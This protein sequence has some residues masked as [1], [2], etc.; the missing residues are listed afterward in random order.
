M[1]LTL[2]GEEISFHEMLQAY[3]AIKQQRPDQKPGTQIRARVG[4][5]TF[6]VV[7]NS[8]QSFTVEA[9]LRDGA[10]RGPN[11]GRLPEEPAEDDHTRRAAL[12]TG[13]VPQAGRRG[14]LRRHGTGA[15]QRDRGGRAPARRPRALGRPPDQSSP[16]IFV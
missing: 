9:F 6:D 15:G 2:I 14:P 5:K 12:A 11:A 4:Q 3:T 16:R 13:S 10:G 1:K 8:D 7:H